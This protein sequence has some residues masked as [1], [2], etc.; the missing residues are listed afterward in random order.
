MCAFFSTK[1]HNHNIRT[2]KSLFKL[3]QQSSFGQ[4]RRW[5]EPAWRA[6]ASRLAGGPACLSAKPL[7]QTTAA[8]ASLALAE[9]TV[10]ICDEINTRS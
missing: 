7:C 8:Q 1:D 6:T 9:L 5:S 2:P 10:L 3:Q 4:Q